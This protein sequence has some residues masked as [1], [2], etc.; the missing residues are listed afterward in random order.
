MT[1]DLSSRWIVEDNFVVNSLSREEDNRVSASIFWGARLDDF[2]SAIGLTIEG[3]GSFQFRVEEQ[4]HLLKLEIKSQNS[5]ADIS[6]LKKFPVDHIVSDESWIPLVLDE[7]QRYSDFITENHLQLGE[8]INLADYMK[9]IAGKNQNLVQV[10]IEGNLNFLTDSA[11]LKSID[12]GLALEPYP[13]QKKGIDWLC[14]V[15]S[16]GVGAILGDEMGLG[17]TV[18]LL[19]LINNELKNEGKPRVLVIV[20]SSLKLN[21][22]SEFNKFLPAL[23]PYIHAGP[24]RQLIPSRIGENEVVITTYPIIN[25][26]WGFLCKLDW[27]LIICDEA[28]V[29]KNPAS[30][31]RDSVR[32][33]ASAPIFLSTGTPLE[34]NLV[35]LWSLTDLIRPGIMGSLHFMKDLVQNQ[36]AEADRIGELVRP[37]I[38]RRIVKNVLPDLPELVEKVHWIEPSLQFTQ[39]YEDVRRESDL[40]KT[41]GS[42]FGLIT[43]LRRFCTYPPL[44]GDYMLNVPDAKV[45]IL[46]DLLDRVYE[47]NQ[48]AIIFTSWHDSA[49]LILRVIQEAYPGVYCAVIDG[50]EVSDIRFP[51]IVDFQ[52]VD[53]FAVLVCNTRAAGEGLNIVAANHVV[54]FDRQ[55]NPAKE[56]QATARS[57]RIGQ[58][59]TVFVHKLVYTG[60]IEEVIDDRLLLKAYLAQQTLD[61]AVKEEDEKSIAEALGIRPTYVNNGV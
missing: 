3:F 38:M 28:H 10:I 26:D 56:A 52:S 33:F 42:K 61:P 24:D 18:Q 2:T 60:T 15:R 35:D 48:K 13:Y 58:V 30:V 1:Q 17:K 45:D 57:H 22:I 12:A 25:R 14:G 59:N 20:P 44:V 34:N 4:S 43:K 9:L 21:W 11:L 39:E 47:Q 53:G 7:A 29:M 31:T 6:K 49:D 8:V 5:A 50:R 41:G 51:K 16:S 27:T 54:H 37:L 36:I 46:L 23:K 55:W 32:K 40:S 19:G